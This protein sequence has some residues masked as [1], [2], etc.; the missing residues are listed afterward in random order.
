[1][2][3]TEKAKG[4]KRGNAKELRGKGMAR[5]SAKGDPR[6]DAAPRKAPDTNGNGPRAKEHDGRNARARGKTRGLSLHDTTGVLTPSVGISAGAEVGYV[7]VLVVSA[8][9]FVRIGDSGTGEGV[10]R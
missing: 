3:K 6:N 8:G 9:V 4:G 10:P 2:G 1:M 7:Y 5:C